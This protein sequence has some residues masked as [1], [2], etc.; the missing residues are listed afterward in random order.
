[1]SPI[2]QLILSGIEFSASARYIADI[3]RINGLAT[4][5]KIVKD[6][7][8]YATYDRSGRFDLMDRIQTK[9]LV[10]VEFWEDT[11]AAYEFIKQIRSNSKAFLSHPGGFWVVEELREEDFPVIQPAINEMEVD[12]E[13]VSGVCGS[14]ASLATFIDSFHYDDEHEELVRWFPPCCTNDWAIENCEH[15]IDLD[16]IE[17]N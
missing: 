15:C 9:A 16:A 3:F 10:K 1:M 17:N 13:S 8:Y 6:E 14:P 11:E 4:A 7:K 12:F 2:K 5:I